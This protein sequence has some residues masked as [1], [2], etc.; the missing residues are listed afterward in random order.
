MRISAWIRI[1]CWG[2]IFLLLTGILICGL[3]GIPFCG[4]SLNAWEDFSWKTDS[5]ATLGNGSGNY[6]V[7]TE[8]I[9]Q[10]DISWTSGEIT[11]ISYEGEDVYF[12][13]TSDTPLNEKNSLR[14][15]VSDG[16]LVIRFQEK[17]SLFGRQPDKK[18]QVMIP[19]SLASD[20]REVQADAVSANIRIEKLEAEKITCTATSGAVALTGLQAGRNRDRDGIW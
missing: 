10:L 7:S 16:V 20:L 9:K 2:V 5:R 12:T 3:T 1:V 18:L 15:G 4:V 11:L 8:G 17:G 19:R 6:H 13:E 14:Y